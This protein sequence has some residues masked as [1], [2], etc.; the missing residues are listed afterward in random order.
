MKT[1]AFS[2]LSLALFMS[3]CEDPAANKPKAN[4][5]NT[6]NTATNTSTNNTAAKTETL[7]VAPDT[8]KVEFT[9]SKVTASHPGGFK[10]FSGTITLADEKPEK[11]KVTVDIDL[12]SVFTNE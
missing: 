10:Q 5:T 7:P 1:L 12:A 3:A 2:V 11:S 8:S 9:A 4:G 6:S